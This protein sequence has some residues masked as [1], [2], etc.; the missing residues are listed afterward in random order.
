M[1]TIIGTA[2]H[3]DHGKTALIKALTGTDTDRL[4][5]EKKRGI[6]IELGFANLIM[7]C[8]RRIGI[9]D[10]PGHERFVC[11]MLAGAGSIG[12]AML[13]V[14]VD[15]GFM[16]QTQEH[17]DILRLLDIKRGMIV[18]TK[19]D[20]VDDDWAELVKLDIAERVEGTFLENAPIM[21]VSAHTGL[22]IEEL[23][24]LLFEMVSVGDGAPDVLLID[25][26][27]SGRVA[28]RLPI[29]R[30]FTMDGF[31]TVVTGTVI[32]G[33]LSVGDN[34]TVFPQGLSARV[35]NIQVHGE[36]TEAAEQ[37]QRAAVN[38][39]GVKYTD[40]EK[41][42]TLATSD[43][44]ELTHLLDAAITILPDCKREIKHNSRLHLYHGTESITCRVALMEQEKLTAG[45]VG[46][47]QLILSS[48]LA[49]KSGDRVVLRFFS[50][51]E[52]VGGA[53]ILDPK[54]ARRKRRDTFVINSFSLKQNGSLSQKLAQIIAEQSANFPKISHIRR[55]WFDNVDGLDEAQQELL[56]SNEILIHDSGICLHKSCI[57]DI[58]AE[59]RSIL[60][61]FHS[62]NPLTAGMRTA[63]LRERILPN[64]DNIVADWVLTILVENAIMKLHENTVALAEFSVKLN[65]AQQ[66]LSDGIEKLYLD[67][68]YATPTPEEALSQ[69]STDKKGFSQALQ[70]LT[71]SGK[72]V[73]LNEQIYLHQIHYTA[74]WDSF[75]KLASAAPE[76]TL[77]DFRD[78]LE[79]S[80]K[81]AVAI[82][83]HFDLHKR[84]RK[85][86]E[87]R[88]VM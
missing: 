41:G 70:M 10:V 36:S 14:A 52:T 61:Q 6:T 77:A 25:K 87:G 84:T 12:I 68:V 48:P 40:L 60:K 32:Q 65:S 49:V 11:N 72:L 22:G 8:G 16:P 88:V 51:M 33:S 39:G 85:I 5:E 63:E 83:E 78:A 2:G 24:E 64:A 1:H 13:V 44:M 19:M 67:T 3:V 56:E 42:S 7:P 21:P 73:K 50:P 86:G 27:S 81:Y 76:V 37:G 30:V 80:R 20:M 62:E 43:S 55:I 58:A 53:V 69:L 38:L 45:E 17:L 71:T 18:L 47:A 79:T 74:A 9:I 34:I 82:L 57:N 4:A 29:D 54:P 31:G 28:F 23:R 26:I 66:K 59:C 35:R 75:V 15:E 46:Y